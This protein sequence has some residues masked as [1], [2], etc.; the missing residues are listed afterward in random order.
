MV[1]EDNNVINF[2][3][4]RES[5]LLKCSRMSSEIL[6]LEITLSCFFFFNAVVYRLQEAKVSDRDHRDSVV[7]FQLGDDSGLVMDENR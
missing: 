3:R 4:W 1:R 2:E 5:D 7:I 6:S